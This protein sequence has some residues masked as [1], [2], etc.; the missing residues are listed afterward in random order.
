MAAGQSRADY[1]HLFANTLLT[2]FRRHAILI[3]CRKVK[4]QSLGRRHRTCP[5]LFPGSAPVFQRSQ[6]SK[7]SFGTFVKTTPSTSRREA[8]RLEIISFTLLGVARLGSMLGMIGQLLSRCG[9]PQP[10]EVSAQT[11]T[12]ATSIYGC[13]M[14]PSTNKSLC[15]CTDHSRLKF[16]LVTTCTD[17]E[18]P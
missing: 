1:S 9:G 17:T 5:S 18:S 13:M 14:S 16:C 7:L 2:K 4:C 8:I 10:H 12:V 11:V 15:L 3:S 6:R